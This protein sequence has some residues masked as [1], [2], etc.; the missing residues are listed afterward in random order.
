MIY[1]IIKAENGDAALLLGPEVLERSA[2]QQQTTKYSRLR[3][4]CTSNIRKRHIAE[5]PF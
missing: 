4:E 5:M 1:G 2:E 3:F